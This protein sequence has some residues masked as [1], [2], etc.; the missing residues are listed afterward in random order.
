[1]LMPALRQPHAAAAAGDCAPL[2]PGARCTS[3]GAAL[4][5]GRPRRLRWK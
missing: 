1:M 3:S 2:E 5:R 4:G